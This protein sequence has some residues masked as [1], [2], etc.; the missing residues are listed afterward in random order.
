MNANHQRLDEG[1]AKF[2]VPEALIAESSMQTAGQVHGAVVQLFQNQQPAKINIDSPK[3][4]SLP[5]KGDCNERK[6]V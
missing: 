5:R 4:V 3:L 6:Q 1:T 2:T